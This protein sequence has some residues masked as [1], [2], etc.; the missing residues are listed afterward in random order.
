MHLI[1]FVTVVLKQKQ[2]LTIYSTVLPIKMKRLTLWSKIRMKSITILDKDDCLI[3]WM[4][5]YGDLSLDNFTNTFIITGAIEY[6]LVAKRFEVPLF[7]L[8]YK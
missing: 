4:L 6:N 3:S 2:Q 5:L 8:C 7:N 1:R